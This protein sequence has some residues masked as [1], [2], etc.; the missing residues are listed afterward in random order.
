MKKKLFIGSSSEEIETAKTVQKLLEN[1]FDVVIWNENLW[2]KSV[3]KL[4]N[5]FLHDL[6]KAPLKFDFG[7][8]IGSPDDKVE[9][10]GKE[11]LQ[12]RDNILFELGLFIGRLGLKRCSFLVHE[13][14]KELS[15]LSGIFISKFNDK[16]LVHKVDE[17]KR[18]FLSVE[19]D[20]FNFFPS[21]TLA[22]GYFENFIKAIC[23]KIIEDGK[24]KVKDVEYERCKFE[25]LVPKKI[26]ENINLQ[27]ER[28]KREVG[29]E[30]VQ[31]ECM[32]RPRPF[33]VNSKFLESGELLIVDFPSTLTGIN[34]AIKELLPDEYRI[35]GEEYENILNRELEKFVFTL[36]GL[37]KKNSFQDFIEIVRV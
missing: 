29:V 36:N 4:N 12:A 6:L 18:A 28:I 11:Y 26:D 14:V 7:I 5:N 35:F 16:N 17:I 21:N 24:L 1:D 33:Q 10:R 22:Y 3:F 31:I 23:A 37:I 20:T 13:N 8:L 2:D 34:Y 15:D 32:G 19:L 25:I 30:Q 27:F 9:V